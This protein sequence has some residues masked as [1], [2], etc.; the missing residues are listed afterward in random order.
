[1]GDNRNQVTGVRL[2]RTEGTEPDATGRKSFRTLPGTEF[3]V[4]ADRVFLALGFESVPLPDE[5]PFDSL[6]LNQNGGVQVD[7]NQMTNIPGVFAGGDLVRGPGT[8][9]NVVRD[10][11]R[12]AEGIQHYL[13]K[14]RP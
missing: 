11:R 3:D 10:A 13:Q 1:L 2:L 14:R 4:P 8:V 12:A 5:P 7:E 9:L 6:T